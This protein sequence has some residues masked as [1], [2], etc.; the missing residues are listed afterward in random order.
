MSFVHHPML[1]I[2]TD[3]RH[4]VFYLI[5]LL[6]FCSI[7]SKPRI[8]FNIICFSFDSFFSQPQNSSTRMKPA[9]LCLD[10]GQWPTR[11]RLRPRPPAAQIAPYWAGV[12]TTAAAA[13]P[14]LLPRGHRWQRNP[15][16]TSGVARQLTLYPLISQVWIICMQV[17]T[18]DAVTVL[19]SLTAINLK[20][21]EHF[22]LG[23]EKQQSNH[24]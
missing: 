9:P 24:Y 17:G 6:G 18:Y 11:L 7:S 10:W 21:F 15:A 14:L 16:G 12:V 20:H 1:L 22:I 23:I 4:Y 13:L 8:T 5:V 2:F 3:L 19:K